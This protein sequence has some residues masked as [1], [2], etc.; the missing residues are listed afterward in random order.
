MTVAD[1]PQFL[2]A[3]NRLA[4]A[5]REKDLDMAQMHVYFEA[6]E[7]IPIEAVT[8]SAHA[9]AKEP[10]RRFFPTSGEWV[11][12]AQLASIEAL[13]NTLPAGRAEPWHHTCDLCQDTGWEGFEC[14]GDSTCGR[15]KPH[16]PHRYVRPCPCRPI[17]QTWLRHLRFGTGA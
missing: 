9:L 4:V 2:Q 7:Q 6:L 12:A 15:S 11:Q 10:G 14:A 17:N 5:L 8:A 1:K 3:I 16:Y 13:R